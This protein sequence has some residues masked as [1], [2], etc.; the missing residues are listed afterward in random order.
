MYT[1]SYMSLSQL[2]CGQSEVVPALILCTPRDPFGMRKEQK[3]KKTLQGY[4]HSKEEKKSEL[5]L[6]MFFEFLASIVVHLVTINFRVKEW[7]PLTEHVHATKLS[8]V[9]LAIFRINSNAK[10][11]LYAIHVQLC[12]QYHVL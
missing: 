10:I 6:F 8:T 12:I 2:A 11:P 5:I 7:H 1:S 4:S 3:K 9:F